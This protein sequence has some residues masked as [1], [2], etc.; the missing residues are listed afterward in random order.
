MAA[1][2][3]RHFHK[4]TPLT[5][6]V[7]V[8]GTLSFI[9]VGAAL[10]QPYIPDPDPSTAECYHNCGAAAA[11]DRAAAAQE[12]AEQRAIARAE[13]AAAAQEAANQRAIA[14]AK[15]AAAAQ[16]AAN[17]RAIARAQRAAEQAAQRAARE[18]A[19]RRAASSSDTDAYRQLQGQASHPVAAAGRISEG[20]DTSGYRDPNASDP[21]YSLYSQDRRYRAA[22]EDVAEAQQRLAASQRRIDDLR[23]RAAA[24]NTTED[25]RVRIHIQISDETRNLNRE[26]GRKRIAEIKRDARRDVILDMSRH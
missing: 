7:S 26:A 15:R 4:T 19:T 5:A 11:E 20:F 3:G 16:E 21:R 9:P 2:S 24:P 25:E 17:Q 22:A 14:R 6:L 10:A 13:R 1:F 18:E 23:A 12:A 8:L